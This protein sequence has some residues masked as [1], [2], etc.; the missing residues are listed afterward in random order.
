MPYNFLIIT[1]SNKTIES[2]E[3]EADF[4]DDLPT[5]AEDDN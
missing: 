2:V 5:A 4:T 1:A 3:V